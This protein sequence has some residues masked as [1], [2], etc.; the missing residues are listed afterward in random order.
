M[1]ATTEAYLAIFDHDGVLVD[2]LEPHQSAWVELGRRTG[3]NLT[4]EFIHATFGMTN[5][6][7]FR[8]LCGDGITEDEIRRYSDLKEEC[9]RDLARGKIVLMDG[10]REVLDALTA[11]GV[12]LA[13]GSS[14][15]R[16]NL[17]LTVSECGLDGRFAAIASL[18]DITRGKPDPEVFL[19]AAAKAGVA[20]IRSVVFEDA[21]F[22]IQAAKAAGMYAVGVTTTHSVSALE[23]AGADEVV[24]N[25]VGYDVPGLLARLK[26]RAGS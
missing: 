6:S 14:G 23:D 3:L 26:A 20:P 9:Y 19:V 18:E 4:P 25:L 16:P 2:S 5:P 1:P 21:T 11:R 13:I 15:V 17:E 12:K 7:I 10:V 8:R 22:G 24:T